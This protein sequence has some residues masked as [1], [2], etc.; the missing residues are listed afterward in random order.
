MGKDPRPKH[1]SDQKPVTPKD[2][3]YF[4]GK[5]EWYNHA[6]TEAEADQLRDVYDQDPE[7]IWELTT[8]AA[9]K[10]FKFSV[11]FDTHNGKGF[12]ASVAC[13]HPRN[14]LHGVVVT[15]RASTAARAM[16]KATYVVAHVLRF[17]EV[18]PQSAADDL[19]F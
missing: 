8:E 2:W 4:S 13:A 6:W 16:L 3:K 9:E 7:A 1:T 5:V 19:W 11:K 18:S 17:G 10:G 15:E 12:T 14:R